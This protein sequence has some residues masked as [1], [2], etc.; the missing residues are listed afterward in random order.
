[1]RV[2][3]VVDIQEELRYAFHQVAVDATLY[4]PL[5][6]Q[7]AQD[8]TAA[9][10]D[11]NLCCTADG[12][13][14]TFSDV[15]DFPKTL[16]KSPNAI[17]LDTDPVAWNKVA[18]GVSVVESRIPTGGRLY[19]PIGNGQAKYWQMLVARTYAVAANLHIS[20]LGLCRIIWNTAFETTNL[21]KAREIVRA[22]FTHTLGT[23]P[24]PAMPNMGRALADFYYH[25]ISKQAGVNSSGLSVLENRLP[26]IRIGPLD[27][28]GDSLFNICPVY[29]ADA[30][31][32]AHAQSVPRRFAPF[33]PSLSKQSMTGIIKPGTSLTAIAADRYGNPVSHPKTTLTQYQTPDWSDE[34]VWNMRVFW[35]AAGTYVAGANPWPDFIPQA[36]MRTLAN[37]V[38][39]DIP[40]D[41]I[42]KQCPWLP[43]GAFGGASLYGGLGSQNSMWFA[44]V[45]QTGQVTYLTTGLVT[46]IS[47][48]NVLT[49]I[50]RIQIEA[51]LRGTGMAKSALQLGG[52]DDGSFW[53]FAF[54]EV[55]LG[56]PRDHTAAE[57][58]GRDATTTQ[59]VTEPGLL[60]QMG[61]GSGTDLGTGTVQMGNG[62]PS[63]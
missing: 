56:D 62:G 13:R 25:V 53:D 42:V 32:Y 15:E 22:H 30:W 23:T 29:L 57:E 12:W 11:N 21:I 8:M 34:E 7:R 41:M 20:A 28:E 48:S 60:G 2:N 3:D 49:G 18:L 54:K 40:V 1:M 16:N 55:S 10:S 46:S 43:G 26:N 38:L 47:V 5:R 44:T 17:L 35:M 45:N 52:M 51:V 63:V 39:N 19:K 24:T 14:V 37:V 59:T 6:V 50:T 58:R 31:I 9:S 4:T 27:Q 36:G 33:P 61:G